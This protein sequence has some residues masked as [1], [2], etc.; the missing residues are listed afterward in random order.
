VPRL[1]QTFHGDPPN[2]TLL[3]PILLYATGQV[4][5]SQTW[6]LESP[7]TQFGSKP[8]ILASLGAKRCSRPYPRSLPY[9]ENEHIG[10]CPLTPLLALSELRPSQP[11][12]SVTL[13]P[14][15]SVG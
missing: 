5:G 3:P 4:W 12:T 14:A 8:P 10:L 7:G 13:P 1:K 15:P 11:I 6:P 2:K 9:E